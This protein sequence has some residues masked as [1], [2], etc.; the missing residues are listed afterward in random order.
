M[1][2]FYHFN[3]V[4][5]KIKRFQFKLACVELV[6]LPLLICTIC[7]PRISELKTKLFYCLK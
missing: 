3:V 5:V 2:D 6:C 7:A 1:I 4:K